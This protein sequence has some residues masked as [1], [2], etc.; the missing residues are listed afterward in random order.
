[1]AAR[2]CAGGTVAIEPD[3]SSASYPFAVAAAT[4]STITVPHLNEKS[5]QGDYGFV[6]VL[7][8]MGC[9]VVKHDKWTQVTG[10]FPSIPISGLY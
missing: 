6:D 5:L 10:A 4:G 8:Q 7:A 9:T 2:C 3:A 1:V